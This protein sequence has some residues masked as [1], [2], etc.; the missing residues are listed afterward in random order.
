M[1]GRRAGRGKKRRDCELGKGWPADNGESV[2]GAQEARGKQEL[3]GGGGTKKGKTKKN[4]R[5]VSAHRQKC[6]FGSPSA[7]AK[8]GLRQQD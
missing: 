5:E 6:E 8:T 7:T 3:K 1:G 4:G 2:G